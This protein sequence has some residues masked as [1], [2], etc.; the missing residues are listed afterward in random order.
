[1]KISYEE[2]DKINI[3]G[4]I[5]AVC[6]LWMLY[7]TATDGPLNLLVLDCENLLI[8]YTYQ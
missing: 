4:D 2:K 1:M 7:D 5:F 3:L 6:L 8:F